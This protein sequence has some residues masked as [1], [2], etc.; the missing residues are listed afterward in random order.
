MQHLGRFIMAMLYMD[1]TTL[2]AQSNV[3]LQSLTE[4]YMHFCKMFWMRLK[5]KKSKV[6]H[7]RRLLKDGE[8]AVYEE[9]GVRAE[10]PDAE[11]PG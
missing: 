7:C 2:V 5:H 3:G 10:Q 6:M 9:G 4:K 11:D 8:D 1:D